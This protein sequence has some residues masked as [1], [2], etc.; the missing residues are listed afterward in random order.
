MFIEAMQ[1]LLDEDRRPWPSHL[2]GSRAPHLAV[3][4]DQEYNQHNGFGI[5][6]TPRLRSMV[7]VALHPRWVFG[8]LARYLVSE[9]MPSYAHYPDAFRTA[10][11]RGLE[12]RL[13]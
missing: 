9:G 5:P 12:P 8:V 13:S 4:P 6:F 11:N 10:I 7:D 3:S 1:C 2:Q